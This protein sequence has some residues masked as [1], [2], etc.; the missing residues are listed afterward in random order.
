MIMPRIYFM[1][2]AAAVGGDFYCFCR[3]TFP[4]VNRPSTDC[5]WFAMVSHCAYAPWTL[6]WKCDRQAKP[7]IVNGWRLCHAFVCSCHGPAVVLCYC[8]VILSSAET[9]FDLGTRL[10]L[11]KSICAHPA[12][13]RTHVHEMSVLF[14]TP[15]DP[16]THTHRRGPGKCS[17][18]SDH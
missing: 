6:L 9:V 16:R 5:C 10:E 8:S 7:S 2:V 17:I 13:F 3:L 15:T 12:T 11:C 1:A 4:L 18:L 14:F